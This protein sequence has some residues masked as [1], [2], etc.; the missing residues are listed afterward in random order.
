MGNSTVYT[1]ILEVGVSSSYFGHFQKSQTILSMPIED[2]IINLS[3]ITEKLH[4]LSIF[5]QISVLSLMI[6]T[7]NLSKI[8]RVWNYIKHILY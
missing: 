7:S 1:Q 3:I 5:L 6:F 2:N 8:I 4:I